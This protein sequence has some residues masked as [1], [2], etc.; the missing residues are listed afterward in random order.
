MQPHMRAEVDKKIGFRLRHEEVF[1]KRKLPGRYHRSKPGIEIAIESA[2]GDR[3][4]DCGAPAANEAPH[5]EAERPTHALP[6]LDDS[7]TERQV[8]RAARIG[9]PVPGTA[10]QE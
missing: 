7:S 4:C 1:S 5:A 2:D 10:N 6:P 3:C 9:E 8:T